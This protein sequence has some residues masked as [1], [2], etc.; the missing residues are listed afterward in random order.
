MAMNL[1][2]SP[3]LAAELRRLSER[4]G[5]SQQELVR[6]AV[7]AYT[8]MFDVR[9]FPEHIRH[10]VRAPQ[11]KQGAEARRFALHRGQSIDDIIREDRDRR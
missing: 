6:E 4:T 3:E 1:R 10:L 9:D 8:Q 7:A 2:L 5:K 11:P